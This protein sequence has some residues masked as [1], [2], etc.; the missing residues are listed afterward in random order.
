MAAAVFPQM[1]APGGLCFL[2]VLP[3][4]IRRRTRLDTD[5]GGRVGENSY[6][7]NRTTWL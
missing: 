2:N 3:E 7:K 6:A 4:R 5:T 1:K